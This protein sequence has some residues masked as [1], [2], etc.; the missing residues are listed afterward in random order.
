MRK[1]RMTSRTSINGMKL[2]SGSSRA[3]ALRSLIRDAPSLALV[4]REIDEL[5]GLLLHLDH[6]AIDLGAEMAVEDHRWN[7]D[8]EAH[9]GVVQRDRDALCERDGVRCR[10]ALRTEDLDHAD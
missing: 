7:G 5:D 6:Q 1:M 10:R 9:G 3:D 4:V 8:D 2:I